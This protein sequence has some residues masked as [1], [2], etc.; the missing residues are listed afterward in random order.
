MVA[1]SITWARN[2]QYGKHDTASIKAP[3]SLTTLVKVFGEMLRLIF[4]VSLSAVLISARRGRDEIWA[5]DRH[6]PVRN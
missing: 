5:G 3:S 2:L 6:N 1:Y 4:V